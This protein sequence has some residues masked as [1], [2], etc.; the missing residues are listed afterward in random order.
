[1]STLFVVAFT[2][3]QGMQDFPNRREGTNIHRNALQDFTLV[4]VHRNF[5]RFSPNAKL[6]VRFFLPKLNGAQGRTVSM[7]AV[8]LQDSSHYFMEAKESVQWK[9]GEWNFFTP[10]PTRDVIDPLGLSP[11]NIGVLAQYRVRNHLPIVLPVDVYQ[12]DTELTRSA[13][14]FYFMSNKDLQSLDV[15]VSDAAGKA[16]LIQVPQLRCPKAH[17]LEC[18][19]YAAGNTYPFDLDLSSLPEGEYHVKLVG[20]VLRDVTPVS[21]PEIV[22]YHHH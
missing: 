13:Y 15:S 7:R 14:T 22:L 11:T 20:H 19:K 6:K 17:N 18:V 1:M 2:Q 21:P 5:N 3:I 4:A 10:W 16:M 8:E 9:D 12:K